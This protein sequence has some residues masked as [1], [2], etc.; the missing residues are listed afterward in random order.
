M[1]PENF[2]WEIAIWLFYEEQYQLPNES[3]LLNT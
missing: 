2:G 1:T 3:N